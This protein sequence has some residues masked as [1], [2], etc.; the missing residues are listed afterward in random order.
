MRPD[1][2]EPKPR[3][4]PKKITLEQRPE[5]DR[6]RRAQKAQRLSPT[7]TAATSATSYS[8]RLP[9]DSP[10]TKHETAAAGIE[11][12]SQSKRQAS[13]EC[14]ARVLAEWEAYC[15]SDHLG[16]DEEKIAKASLHSSTWLAHARDSSACDIKGAGCCTN[17]EEPLYDHD[18]S[19]NQRWAN[20]MASRD[21][22]RRVRDDGA[23]FVERSLAVLAACISQMPWGERR[24]Q[25][26]AVCRQVAQAIA[27][28]SSLAV[29]A[30]PAVGKTL[31]ILAPAALHAVSTG[32]KVVVACDTHLQQDYLNREVLPM[33]ATMV[34]DVTSLSLS[35][36]VFKGQDNYLCGDRWYRLRDSRARGARHWTNPH[37]LNQYEAEKF[38]DWRFQFGILD[39]WADGTDTGDFAELEGRV[40]KTLTSKISSLDCVH[41]ANDTTADTAAC[42]Y[43]Q[44][45]RRA[46]QVDVL[47]S[48]HHQYA[49][50][51]QTSGKILP[52][53]AYVVVE[54][55]DHFDEAI[56]A[57]AGVS[58]GFLSK[59]QH[60]HTNVILSSATL[61]EHAKQQFG[62][63]Q[64][65]ATSIS[66]SAQF[67]PDSARL[68]VPQH[69]HSDD[70]DHRQ[71]SWSEIEALINAIK[72]R[73]ILLFTSTE[74][75]EETHEHLSALR[76]DLGVQIFCQGELPKMELLD[77]LRPKY[78]NV[79][80]CAT[81]SF[82][83][84]IDI[85]GEGLQLVV[86]DKMPYA[87]DDLNRWS[88]HDADD[89]AFR[90]LIQ[91]L[92]RLRRIA[93][94]RG[95]AAILD[96]RFNLP[97]NDQYREMLPPMLPVTTQDEAVAF[98][99]K[100]RRE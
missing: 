89:Y 25:Q 71:R 29:Q 90:L 75:M 92:N 38:G 8:A 48:N 93:S 99:E 97:Q 84:S 47:V 12:G 14:D 64:N 33:L 20:I 42:Y 76:R 55:A 79:V 32:G 54:N 73:T 60:K 10:Q 88:S 83:R 68:Y 67:A 30:S 46:E 34:R 72:G 6:R 21:R 18:F 2:N 51:L 78:N 24:G 5:A 87:P 3:V 15:L 43:W 56:S 23:E 86:L 45:R 66:A 69:L 16:E 95:L 13:P 98:L 1:D 35:H 65:R 85:P 91:G 28:F 49:K 59:T 80:V 37:F 70:P 77:V 44:A 96:S 22:G 62:V 40:S 26:V 50:D 100:L 63:G 39:T 31:A 52:Q 94:D 9:Q 61:H 57:V 53:H 27:S 82:W 19:S 4:K 81:K 36:G 11:Q 74:A 17:K 41:G 58:D 7:R